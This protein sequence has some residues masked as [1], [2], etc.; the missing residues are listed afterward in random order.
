MASY[1]PYVPNAGVMLNAVYYAHLNY[2]C[3][4]N[5]FVLDGIGKGARFVEDLGSGKKR[6][7]GIPPAIPAAERASRTRSS[8]PS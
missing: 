4:R 2:R 3:D 6:A 5:R 7:S 8:T 1:E